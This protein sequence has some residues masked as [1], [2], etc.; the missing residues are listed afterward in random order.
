MIDQPAFTAR[1]MAWHPLGDFHDGLYGGPQ[2]QRPAS[3]DCN[4]GTPYYLG[5]A[6][7]M[8]AT[9]AVTSTSIKHVPQAIFAMSTLCQWHTLQAN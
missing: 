5:G 4:Y 9:I 8:F 3:S 7:C 2:H 6:E 1:L